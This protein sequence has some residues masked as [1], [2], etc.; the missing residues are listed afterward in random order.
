MEWMNDPAVITIGLFFA[1]VRIWMET[2]GFD[3]ARLP[4][5]ARA[6]AAPEARRF[7]RWGFYF[8]VLYLITFAPELLLG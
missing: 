6:F 1:V 8:S 7:H 3:F 4:L 2:V 5:T